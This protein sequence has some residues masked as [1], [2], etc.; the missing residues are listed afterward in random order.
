MTTPRVLRSNQPF[1]RVAIGIDFSASARDALALARARFPEAE[2]LLIHVVDARAAAVPDISGAGMV[3]VTSSPELI[4]TLT[5]VDKHRLDDLTEV[6]ESQETVT[7]DPASA[8]VEAAEQ[9]GADLI[10]VGSHQQ[11]AIEHF[12]VG[13]VAEQVLKKARVP[14]LVVKVGGQS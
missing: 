5:R 14:V 4:N 13:S 9:W 11:G 1:S 2:R 7:G 6:G 12:F 10:V 3:P 8:L